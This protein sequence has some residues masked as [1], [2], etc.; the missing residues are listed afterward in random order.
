MF[1]TV[2]DIPVPEVNRL[3]ARLLES[4]V[5]LDDPATWPEDVW[6]CD[7]ANFAY[8]RERQFTP[9]WE[10]PCGL[11]IRSHG[12]FWGEVWVG[13]EFHCAENDNPLF[14]CPRPGVPCD[15]RL[16]YPA[17]MNC[18][19]HR[20]DRVWTESGSCERLIRDRLA[21][22]R[23]W[24]EVQMRDHPGFDGFCA[25]L[26]KN[27]L[28]D[29]MFRYEKNYW[30]E[31]CISLKCK[32]TQCPCLGWKERDVRPANIFY[33]LYIE[34]RFTEGLVPYSEKSIIKGLKVFDKAVAMHDAELALRIWEKNPNA[35]MLP[36]QMLRRLDVAV[37]LENNIGS[38]EVYFV[39]T[40]GKLHERECRVHAEIR[41]IRVARQ[42][43]RDLMQDLQD[44]RDGITVQH[45]SDMQKAAKAQ[46][47]ERYQAGKIKRMAQRMAKEMRES[48]AAPED[49]HVGG[50][51]ER[52]NAEFSAAVEAEA[53]RIIEKAEEK[54]KLEGIKAAQISF[55]IRCN[56]GKR[57]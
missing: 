15:H 25:N 34:R 14:E 55:S 40:H 32:N 37:N 13:G 28:P 20:T 56:E 3:T 30:L 12:D 49:T 41:N 19:F 43:G 47:N 51:L 17:G 53:M 1:G 35:R 52:R 27:E 5:A 42:E 22:E 31:R 8:K 18:Q 24:R 54:K 33:D 6:R 38:K 46:K 23:Q 36:S 57:E 45:A 10:S 9:T 21:R 16:P 2:I 29:G 50:L 48:G 4:G 7:R 44:V 26:R 39:R 11:L